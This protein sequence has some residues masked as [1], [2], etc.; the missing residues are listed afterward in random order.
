MLGIPHGSV[1]VRS[2][3]GPDP[4]SCPERDE[5]PQRRT[6]LPRPRVLPAPATTENRSLRSRGVGL[7][8]KGTEAAGL[9]GIDRRT[10]SVLVVS[11]TGLD[12][13]GLTPV[14]DRACG[15]R[16][17]HR[18]GRH[19]ASL[20]PPSKNGTHSSTQ[21][22]SRCVEHVRARFWKVA[23]PGTARTRFKRFTLAWTM[24]APHIARLHR[25]KVRRL[26]RT[27]RRDGSRSD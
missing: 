23:A 19:R 25:Y 20:R 2:L 27:L 15:C 14:E 13:S 1:W 12:T 18:Q 11:Q 9:Q 7:V 3:N 26:V 5:R 21:Y 10:Q 17:I 4:V 8:L 24:H 6:D 16:S 22:R